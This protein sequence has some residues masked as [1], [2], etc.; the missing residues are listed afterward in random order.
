MDLNSV[1]NRESLISIF[2]DLAK[3]P[4][5]CITSPDILAYNCIAWAMGFESRWVSHIDEPYLDPIAEKFV[6]WPEGVEISSRC[7]ALVSAFITLGFEETDNCEFEPLYDKAILYR[8]GDQWT[9][10]SRLIANGIEH[11]KFGGLWDA[12]H[13]NNVFLNSPYGIPYAYMRRLHSQK[14]YYLD[15]YPITIGTITINEEQ[16]K[17]TLSRL[18]K[19]KSK[20]KI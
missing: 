2:P 19:L 15:L 20:S 8:K 5:F 1:S 12:Q 18:K 10:A 6:W 17:R 9:H 16:L 11:S 13:S 7:E 4:N 14:Q 3:D